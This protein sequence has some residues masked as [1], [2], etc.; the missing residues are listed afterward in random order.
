MDLAKLTEKVTKILVAP[1]TDILADIND[2]LDAAQEDAEERYQFQPT[3]K[4]FNYTFTASSG[5]A[6]SVALR[7]T[8]WI[9]TDSHDKPYYYVTENDQKVAKFLTWA[10][11]QDDALM[12]TGDVL[13]TGAPKRLLEA[14]EGASGLGAPLIIVLP[15]VDDDYEVFISYFA[16]LTL[17]SQQ[18]GEN[19]FMEKW[20]YYLIWKSAS[21]LLQ[22]MRNFELAALYAGKAEGQFRQMKRYDKRP[23]LKHD[24]LRL[25]RDAN[26][27]YNQELR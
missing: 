14:G 15:Q 25:K 19:W 24:T 7:P 22:T 16:H 17:P 26:A 3:K 8:D 23:R 9:R 12:A 11:D 18:S 10:P 13:Q 20:P 6:G 21:E 4:V 1:T 5:G 2:E 27:P